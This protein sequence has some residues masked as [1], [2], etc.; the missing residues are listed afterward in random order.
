M[1]NLE[2]L[3]C[4]NEDLFMQKKKKIDPIEKVSLFKKSLFRSRPLTLHE[5]I[6]LN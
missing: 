1:K 6:R 3:S 4:V 2:L 5:E